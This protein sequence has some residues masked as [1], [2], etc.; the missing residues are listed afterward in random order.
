[1]VQLQVSQWRLITTADTQAEV[2]IGK[3]SWR[4]GWEAVIGW[5]VINHVTCTVL[6]VK[7]AVHW[8]VDLY[9]FYL[10]RR[11]VMT[12]YLS[13]TGRQCKGPLQA[14]HVKLICCFHMWW[15]CLMLALAASKTCISGLAVEYW[16]CDHEVTCSNLTCG[17]CVYCVPTPTQHAVPPWSVNEY[18]WKLG[19]KRA[20]HAMH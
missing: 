8:L 14:C 13:C 1:M 11:R 19:S 20:Y 15:H 18:Q 7:D 12:T 5:P 3:D 4:N 10:H 2:C 16:S 6:Q 17:Y 9:C